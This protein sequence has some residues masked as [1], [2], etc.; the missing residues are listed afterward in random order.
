MEL[1]VS[2]SQLNRYVKSLLE[3][4]E[5]LSDILVSGEIGSLHDHY[6][7]GHIYFTL[8]DQSASVRAVLFK[9]YAQHL[10]FRPENGMQVTARASASLYERDGSY[11]LY[12]RELIPAGEGA[13]YQEFVKIKERL[14]KEG[15]FQSHRKRPLPAY[16]QR[17]GVVTSPEG[18][19]LRDIQ[20]VL[21]RRWPTGTLVL[22]PCTV[23][24]ATAAGSVLKALTRLEGV[25]CDLVIIARGGGSLE[26]LWGF[27]DEALARAVAAFPVPVISAVGH[28]TDFTICDFV[29]DLRAPTPSAA[30]ELATPDGEALLHQL[31]GMKDLLYERVERRIE[32]LSMRVDMAVNRLSLGSPQQRLLRME[33]RLVSA[34]AQLDAGAKRA[35]E[36]AEQRLHGAI[37]RLEALSPLKTLARGFAA[38]EKEGQLVRRAEALTPGDQLTARF[39]DGS[40]NLEVLAIERRGQD[41]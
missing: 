3:E 22:S 16:P 28:E 24:G 4:N 23:Q 41:G 27:N 33:Q 36:R 11:Q 5:A 21:R 40:V 26:D 32:S 29:S 18:A 14:E 7:S 31:E 12:V 10:Q 39:V 17:I 25:G 15:L 6:S 13:L 20:N 34:T 19:V 30:A 1:Q 8:K 38:V 35:A 9:S 37:G 2:V